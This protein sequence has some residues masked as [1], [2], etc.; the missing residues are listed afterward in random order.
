MVAHPHRGYIG[1]AFVQKTSPWSRSQPLGGGA[2]LLED[3]GGLERN[4][5]DNPTSRPE[6][7]PQVL[8]SR[9][10]STTRQIRRAMLVGSALNKG[11]GPVAGAP[12]GKRQRAPPHSRA[13]DPKRRTRRPAHH[14]PA[15]PPKE[16]SHCAHPYP[17][18]WPQRANQQRLSDQGKSDNYF[19]KNFSCLFRC[20]RLAALKARSLSRPGDK[21]AY[22]PA[23]RSDGSPRER[24]PATPGGSYAES[25][26]KVIPGAW[27]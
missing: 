3:E 24:P 21:H 2:L 26:D 20:A 15:V 9:R 23:L 19:G 22:S 7:A 12:P 10:T 6:G 18:F 14:K 8:F 17:L 1:Q 13:P 4:P 27:A 11:A 25:T 5:T 16:D